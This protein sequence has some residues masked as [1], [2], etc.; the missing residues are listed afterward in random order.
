MVTNP[1]ILKLDS[2]GWRSTSGSLPTAVVSFQPSLTQR[3]GRTGKERSW[4]GGRRRTRPR[5]RR[6]P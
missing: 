4:K 5:W 2:T 3:R 6:S 1:T